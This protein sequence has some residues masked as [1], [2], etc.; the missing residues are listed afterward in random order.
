MSLSFRADLIQS[1]GATDDHAGDEAHELQTFNHQ[2]AQTS[3]MNTDD[4]TTGL[5]RV[6]ER[7][8]QV[9]DGGDAEFSPGARSVL[10]GRVVCLSKEEAESVVVK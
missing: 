8:H 10:H 7:A 2:S 6:A 1:I 9:E 3:G 4:D 5:G